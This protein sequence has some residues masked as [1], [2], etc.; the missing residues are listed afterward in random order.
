M[1]VDVGP[2]RPDGPSGAGADDGGTV[3]YFQA[4]NTI[5]NYV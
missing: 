1:N 3:A 5:S 2:L 4:D